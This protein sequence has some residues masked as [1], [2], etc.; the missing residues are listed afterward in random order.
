MLGSWS[1]GVRFLKADGSLIGTVGGPQSSQCASAADGPVASKG[2]PT[3]GERGASR[4][5]PTTGERDASRESRE[6]QEK[7]EHLASGSA[8]AREEKDAVLAPVALGL[9]RREATRRVEAILSADRSE[10]WEAGELA[11]AVLRQK[12]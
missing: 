3:T 9:P 12:P 10:V 1:T 7:G 11:V 8:S 2:A 5:A 4:E 6:V